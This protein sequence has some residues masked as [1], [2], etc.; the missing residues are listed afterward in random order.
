MIFDVMQDAIPHNRS[1]VAVAQMTSIGDTL[2]NYQVC[3]KLVQVLSLSSPIYLNET[4][5]S[6]LNVS[7]LSEL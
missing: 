5:F 2:H 6:I 3:E 4:V 7:A 1:K